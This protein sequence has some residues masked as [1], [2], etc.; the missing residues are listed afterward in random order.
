MYYEGKW[1]SLDNHR[2]YAYKVRHKLTGGPLNPNEWVE[3]EP[4]QEFF[5]KRQTVTDGKTISVLTKMFGLHKK[6][7]IY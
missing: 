6:Y 7:D 2:L 1:W 5:N 4:T 3:V